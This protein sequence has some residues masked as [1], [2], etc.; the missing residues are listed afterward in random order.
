[1]KRMH[2]MTS[3]LGGFSS[4][5][6]L[7]GKV[8]RYRN[9]QNIYTQGA[10]AYTIFY[11]QEGGVRLTSRKKHQPPAVT[12]ILGVGDFFGELCLAGYPLRVSTAIALAA[13]SIRIIQ[14]KKMI[15]MLRKKNKASNSLVAYLLSS[16]KNYQDHVADLLTSS[17]EQRLARVL[18]RLAHLDRKG[19]ALVEIPVLSHQVL[20][21]MVGTTRPRINLFMNRF[22]KQGFIDYDG[23]LEVRPSLRK[24]LRRR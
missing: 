23:G 19:P 8:S 1:M 17:A 11:I 22:R 18:L 5:D 3:D 2:P 20:A 24:V 9:K 13:S 15:Q 16:V 12:A 14:K 6:S 4:G 21:E 10:P 7:G